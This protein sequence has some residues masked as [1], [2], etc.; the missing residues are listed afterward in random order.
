MARK[1]IP[2]ELH[3]EA[4]QEFKAIYDVQWEQRIQ[5]RDDRRFYSIAGAQWEGRIG[6]AYANRPKLE[7]NKVL[8]SVNRI[9]NEYKNNRISVDFIA[10][11]KV[12]D[13]D[14]AKLCDD[15]YRADEERS[16]AQEAYD[17]A[18]EEGI[19][20]GFG[21]WR[22][23]AEYE[24]EY[25]EENEHQVIEFEPIPDA[26]IRVFFDLDAKRQ[27]KAD[28]R[29]CFV[30]VPMTR[31]RFE[32]E[33]GE[34]ETGWP[35]DQLVTDT[36]IDVS[37]PD[38]VFACEYYMTKEGRELVHTYRAIDGTEA[39]VT[40]DELDRDPSREERMDASGYLK[41]GERKVKRK[42]VH[43]YI[44]GGSGVLEDCGVIAGGNIP[45][46]PFYGRRW[47]VDNVERFMGHVRPAR[48]A[49]VLKNMQI[50][51]LAD[52]A[53]RS[54]IEKPI[55]SREQTAGYDHIWA[56]DVVND[57]PYMPINFLTDVS[58]NPIPAGPVGYTKP[59]MVAPAMAALLQ[60]SET[61]IQEI[62]GNQ[63]GGD[64]LVS[65]VSGAAIE[66]VQQRID[67][68]AFVYLDNFAKAMKRCGVV[69]LGMAREL[70]VEEGRTLRTLGRQ[71]QRGEVE[72]A[73][74][75]LDGDTGDVFYENDL[76]QAR[77]PVTVDIGPATEAKRNA[78]VRALSQLAAIAQNPEDA[79]LAWHATF[80]LL[81]IEG[82]D[83]AREW[84]RK[85]LVQMGA[86]P[87]NEEE[88]KALQDQAQKAQEPDEQQLLMI[89]GAKELEAKATKELAD[90]EYTAARTQET[91]AK[92]TETLAGI[93]QREREIA[94]QAAQSIFGQPQQ[95][96]QNRQPVQPQ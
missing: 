83:D 79:R 66:L 1:P 21:A 62:L 36:W 59:P 33:Y 18:F 16:N 17:T 5:A 90:A 14:L 42:E 45:I 72:V 15:L 92:T 9:G 41:V 85:I 30:L 70:L 88:Q 37:A 58:G 26:D 57:Y 22:L 4:L 23:C 77:F 75:V 69:W 38:V 63:N 65:N 73:R 24:D 11:G 60:I 13:E 40:Q 95:P 68:G 50:S 76:T 80:R 54:S 51:K 86:E 91:I 2:A 78:A 56:N 43:K 81:D 27:D 39:R 35:V 19:G 96:A 34:G 71:G 87:P 8:Q 31:S 29:R 28:A 64:E 84:S 94:N 93:D 20:G 46:I 44:L 52:L 7:V 55:F 67:M 82:T 25:D 12:Q 48:D 49:Q 61:D 74:P 89:A 6:E 32:E 10:G 53:A 47:Y 3:A